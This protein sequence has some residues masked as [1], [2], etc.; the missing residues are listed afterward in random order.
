MMSEKDLKLVDAIRIAMDAE[1][2]AAAYYADSAQK[3]SNPNGRA[4]FEQLAEFE[5][6]HLQKLTNLEKSLREKGAF[7]GYEGRELTIQAPSKITKTREQN[8]LSMMEIIA[9]ALDL[10]RE[11]GKRYKALAKQTADPDG[12]AMF[13]RLA[14]EEQIHYAVL[15]SASE[16]LNQHGVWNW[17]K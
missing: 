15:Y 2:K 13:E 17:S 8:K 16:N 11:A 6:Y 10:E 9:L 3:T 7:I 14:R 4:L 1:E 5:R 12:K